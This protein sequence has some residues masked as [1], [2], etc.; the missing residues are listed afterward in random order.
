MSALVFALCLGLVSSVKVRAAEDT[1]VKGVYVD[2]ID[3]SGMTEA[4]V[5]EVLENYVKDLAAKKVTIHVEENQI[6]TTLEELGFTAT[7]EDLAKQAIEVAKSGNLIKRFKAEKDLETTPMQLSVEKALDDE[8][9]AAFVET[10]KEFD[11]EAKNAT[12]TRKDGAFVYGESEDGITVDVEATRDA[13]NEKFAAGLSEEMD[14]DAAMTVLEPDWKYED[15]IKCN[16]VIGTFTTGYSSSTSQRAHNVAH[17]VSLINGS[18]LYPGEELNA[19]QK[20]AP[21]TLGNGYE[22]AT[23]Y[24]AGRVVDAVAGGICQVATTLYNAAL[25]AELEITQRSNHSMLVDYVEP[26]RD[27]TITDGGYKNL[28]FINNTDAPIYIVGY[29]ENRKATF[30]IYGEA[31]PAGREV[32]LV[33]TTTE[34]T[35]P[36]EDI[37]TVDNTKPYGYRKVEQSAHVGKKAYLTMIIYQNGVE[38]SRTKVN[39]SVYKAVPRYVTV[40][41]EK[42]PE[43][44]TKKPETTTQ[45][46]TETTT[47]AEL[48]TQPDVPDNGGDTGDTGDTGDE[49]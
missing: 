19:Y 38:V 16:T 44:T 31:K 7:K 11:R 6:E 28:K 30:T 26:A 22:T 15:V 34:T 18:V 37:E 10:A 41:P 9:I 13:L 3:L 14:L 23:G 49:G 32:K 36:G 48:P 21:L 42:P 25:Y 24:E 29:T 35:Q 27:A 12:I 20:I 43:T 45:K 8:K 33:S 5:E 2:D 46:Q 4:E 1:V 17:A 47:A 40:G 39:D